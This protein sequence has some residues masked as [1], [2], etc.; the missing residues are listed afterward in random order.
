MDYFACCRRVLTNVH[1][2]ANSPGLDIRLG[3]KAT[4]LRSKSATTVAVFNRTTKTFSR[5][6]YQRG[7]GIAGMRE[8]SLT[9]GWLTFI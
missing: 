6:K 5:N 3:E 2:H 8:R 7:V 9:G 4:R 1:R